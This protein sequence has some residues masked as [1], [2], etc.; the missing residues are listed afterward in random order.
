[1]ERISGVILDDEKHVVN[2]IKALLP[3]D[4]IGIEYKG[5]AY[6][7]EDGLSLVLSVHPDIVITDIMMPGMSGLDLIE[8]THRRFPEIEFIIISGYREFDYAQTAIRSGVE[9][10]LLKPIDR[11][12]L[13]YIHWIIKENGAPIREAPGHYALYQT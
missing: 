12:E 1:M 7:G 9:N 10:Y 4:E 13:N 6:N 2:L 3:W 5:E 8:E 11:D